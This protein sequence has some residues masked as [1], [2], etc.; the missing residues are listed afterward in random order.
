MVGDLNVGS[1]PTLGP[2]SAQPV[3]QEPD[4]RDPQVIHDRLPAGERPEFL[5]QYRAAADAARADIAKYRALQDLLARWALTAEA[6][7][8]PAYNEA[9]AE[10]RAATTPG[11]SMAQ[12]DAMRHGA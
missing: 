1:A 12:V 2:M 11:L 9:L 5:R 4:P 6:L 7:N 10:A 8:D 3:R